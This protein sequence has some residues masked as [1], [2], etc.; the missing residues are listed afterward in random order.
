MWVLL[1][2]AATM[3]AEVTAGIVFNSMALLAD[4]L[5][6]AT[7]AGV[8]LIAV[9][10]YRVAWRNRANSKFSFGTGKVGD[11]AAFASALALAATAV[12][13]IIESVGRLIEPVPISFNEAIPVAF[14]GLIVNVLSVWLLHDGPDHAH[15]HHGHSHGHDH[16]HDHHHHD[17]NLRAAYVHVLADAGLSVLAIAGLF[18]ARDFGWA[19]LD[20]VLGILAGIV[21]LRWAGALLM[22][23]GAV[24]LDK[25]PDADFVERARST[26][27]AE[28]ACLTDFHVWR[29]GPGHYG[30][31]ASL[32]NTDEPPSYYRRRLTKL[33]GLAHITIEI[34]Q[35]PP[36]RT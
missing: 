15:T 17:L 36:R 10:A 14:L 22:T 3:V 31:I 35:L 23:A 30:L 6:M 33:P 19:W 18:A 1:L 8:M 13:L 27:V 16:A 28:G 25:L 7:H 29:L 4:G 9:A 11:L 5:H 34:N 12:F 21:I 26:L 24:L 2:C 32:T 20:P